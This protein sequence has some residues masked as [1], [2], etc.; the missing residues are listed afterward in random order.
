MSIEKHT[1]KKLLRF[2]RNIVI[3]FFI[4]SIGWAIVL[5]F[6]PVYVTPLM[7]IRSIEA[8]VEGKKPKNSKK[9][10]PLKAIS[11]YMVQA[12]VASEDNSFMQHNGFSL[13]DIQDAWAQNQKGKRIRGGSTISQQTAKNVF[14]WN[15]RSYLRKGL[16]AYFTVLIELFWSKKRIMEVYLNV[17]ETGNGI[18][19]I[20]AASL[21]FFGKKASE[22]SRSQAA[23]IAVC[24]PNPLRF[25]PAKPSPYIQR[26]QTQILDLMLK[27]PPIDLDGVNKQQS[28]KQQ[29]KKKKR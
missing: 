25:N 7:L 26:R 4:T 11:P 8:V 14:L 19:G 3:I 10:V 9:W 29:S 24:L 22:L 27:I 13:K 5:R 17:I 12:V 28:K 2:I 21:E 1:L 15:K 20:E 6:V 18:Y 16:E 23:L